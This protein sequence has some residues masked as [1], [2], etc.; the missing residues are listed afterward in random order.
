MNAT[1][2]G[3]DVAKGVIQIHGVDAAGMVAL[4]KRLWRKGALSFLAGLKPCLVGIEAC[5]GAHYWARELTSFGH[6]V[7]RRCGGDLRGG[8]PA[9]HALCASQKPGGAGPGA[10]L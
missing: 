6:Q 9:A 7:R 5:G 4:R 1:T 8:E 3:F 2:I 10:G